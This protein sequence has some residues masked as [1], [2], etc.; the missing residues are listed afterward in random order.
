[1]PTYGRKTYI[2]V[3]FPNSRTHCWTDSQLVC[4]ITERPEPLSFGT[5]ESGQ[6]LVKDLSSPRCFMLQ[7]LAVSML[8]AG[9]QLHIEVRHL[10][11]FLIT[12]AFHIST[13]LCI[14]LG[15]PYLLQMYSKFCMC[16]SGCGRK[17][18]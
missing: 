18:P 9:D 15:V 5:H 17:C 7:K 3:Y 13:Y 11:L 16:C 2:V 4:A 10:L 14:N 8:D 12:N 6:E 1:M